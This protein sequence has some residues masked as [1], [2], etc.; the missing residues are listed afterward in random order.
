VYTQQQTHI[1]VAVSS[2]VGGGGDDQSVV[3]KNSLPSR[4]FHPSTTK[5]KEIK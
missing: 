4:V 3:G 2:S 5:R 1:Q